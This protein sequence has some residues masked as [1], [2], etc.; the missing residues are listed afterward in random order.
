MDAGAMPTMIQ[1]R[2]VPDLLHRKLKARAAREGKSLSYYLLREIERFAEAPTLEEIKT[3]LARS[4][5]VNPLITPAE[6]IRHERDN[7]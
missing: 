3:R 6:I 7:R 5:S 1:I 4:S 2:H